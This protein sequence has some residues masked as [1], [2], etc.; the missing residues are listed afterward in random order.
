MDKVKEHMAECVPFVN[1]G[2][3]MVGKDLIVE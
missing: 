1:D 2:I 3:M